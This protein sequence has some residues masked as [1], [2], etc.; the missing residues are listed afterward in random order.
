MTNKKKSRS[1]TYRIFILLVLI[2]IAGV[3]GI[4]FGFISEKML[5]WFC[6][7]II[8]WHIYDI[9][10]FFNLIGFNHDNNK[11]NSTLNNEAKKI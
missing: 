8:L 6:S 10:D 3:A 7:F 1:W 2:S 9:Y 11:P 5:P 4:A